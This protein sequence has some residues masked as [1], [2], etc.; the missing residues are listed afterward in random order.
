M[1]HIMQLNKYKQKEIYF[2]HMTMLY[3]TVSG[4]ALI[5]LPFV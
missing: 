5:Q 4:L 2:S 3:F 1:R